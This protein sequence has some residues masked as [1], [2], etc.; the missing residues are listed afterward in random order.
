MYSPQKQIVFYFM[1]KFVADARLMASTR[2]PTLLS[3]TN[4]SKSKH[5]ALLRLGSPLRNCESKNFEI[6]C[7][8][9]F[10]TENPAS[11]REVDCQGTVGALQ[12]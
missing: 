11:L 8:H 12:I 9:L 4:L 10:S 1:C 2:V 6:Y 3:I 5:S 7:Y